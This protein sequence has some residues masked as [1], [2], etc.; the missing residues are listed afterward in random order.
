MV[1]E[2]E[3]RVLFDFELDDEFTYKIQAEKI[4]VWKSKEADETILEDSAISFQVK[5]GLI[6]ICNALNITLGRDPIDYNLKKEFSDDNLFELSIINLPYIANE[7]RPVSFN[8]SS[9]VIII[10]IRT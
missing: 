6:E 5:E 2:S 9:N 7:I 1:N 3:D 4:I 10:I 8:S